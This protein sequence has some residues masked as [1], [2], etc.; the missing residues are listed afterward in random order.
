LRKEP[1][2]LLLK[3]EKEKGGTRKIVPKTQEVVTIIVE[4]TQGREAKVGRINTQGMEGMK[5]HR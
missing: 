5:Y 4:I 3:L 2:D 1:K